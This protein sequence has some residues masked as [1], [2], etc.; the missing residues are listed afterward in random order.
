MIKETQLKFCGQTICMYFENHR[1]T[2]T[3]YLV[4]HTVFLRDIK[5]DDTEICNYVLKILPS[6]QRNQ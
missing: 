2:K 4:K 6:K 3:Q 1:N 5:V